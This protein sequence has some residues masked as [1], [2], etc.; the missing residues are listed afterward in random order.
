MVLNT[1]SGVS[2][3]RGNGV[4]RTQP[5]HTFAPCFCNS[6]HIYRW[7]ITTV[8]C[9]GAVP[10]TYRRFFVKRLCIIL[11]CMAVVWGLTV[12]NTA[13]AFLGMSTIP[14]V[15][16]LPFK[17]PSNAT[18]TGTGAGLLSD[19]SVNFGWLEQRDGSI[20]ALER[21]NSTGTAVWPLK[22]FWVQATE[23]LAFDRNYGLL[24]SAGVLI[25][26]HTSG[27]WISRPAG[28]SFGFD[29][30]SYDWWYLDGMVKA[31]IAG[32]F[33]VLRVSVGIT[34]AREWT[35]ATIQATI[36]FSIPICRSSAPKS[37]SGFPMVRCWFVSQVHRCSLA[38]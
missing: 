19:F 12:A 11:V 37:T 10:R 29:I 15:G 36:I 16:G 35:I 8:S 28:T 7:G 5:K 32:G 3:G 4:D 27:T 9:S 24:I 2:R 20:W 13:R 31:G 22:G 1:L 18:C 14:A 6:E 17:D 30:P 25:P 26:R 38:T 23:D 33:D 34:R 21:Q